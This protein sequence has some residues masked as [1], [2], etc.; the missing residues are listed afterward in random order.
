MTKGDGGKDVMMGDLVLLQEE[1]NAVMSALLEHGLDVTA[2]HNHFFWE[3]PR[4][5]YMHIHG[6]GKA[7]D[8]A[9]EVKPAL[10]LIGHA[11]AV[12]GSPKSLPTR[13][14]PGGGTLDQSKIAEIVGHPGEQAGGV[15]KITVG[16]DDLELKEMGATINARMGLNTW[17]AFFGTNENA[18]VAGDVAMLAGEVT[19]VLK[20]LRKIWTGGGGDPP[21]YDWRA[22]HDHL[23]ALLGQRAGRQARDRLQG[24]AGRTGQRASGDEAAT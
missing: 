21:P 13:I 20:T 12:A 10:E 14:T 17:A 19:R 16:R 23:F 22:P 7:Q 11:A 8:L 24:C 5:F 15:Y 2:L 6:R 4:I 1:V 3:E 9:R 18:I